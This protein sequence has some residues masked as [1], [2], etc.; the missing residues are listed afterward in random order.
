MATTNKYKHPSVVSVGFNK[1]TIVQ[2]SLKKEDLYG[3]VDFCKNVLTIDP[4]QD[5][6]NYLLF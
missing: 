4:K 1:Y 6:M 5:G 2:A 3:C